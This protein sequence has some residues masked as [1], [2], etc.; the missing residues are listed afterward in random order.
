MIKGGSSFRTLLSSSPP[1]CA[2]ARFGFRSRGGSASAP[3]MLG[4]FPG[5]GGSI[6]DYRAA[7][8][9]PSPDPGTNRI[10]RGGVEASAS[11]YDITHP[12]SIKND[13]LETSP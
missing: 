13:A 4:V 3:A 2:V 12:L 7:G 5:R 8:A 6:G 9:V 11:R 1:I 10:S